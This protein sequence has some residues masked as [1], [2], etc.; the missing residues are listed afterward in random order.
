MSKEDIEKLDKQIEILKKDNH[1]ITTGEV[2]KVVTEIH[3]PNDENHIINISYINSEVKE[4]TKEIKNLKTLTTDVED[5]DDKVIE[6]TKKISVTKNLDAIE[7]LELE[8]ISTKVGD[9]KVN[10]KKSNKNLFIILSVIIGIL[11]LILVISLFIFGDNNDKEKD[12]TVIDEGETERVLS[13]DKMIEMV[14]LYG[15]TLEEEIT[16]YYNNSGVLPDFSTI[17]NLVNLDYEVVCHIHEIYKDKSI[18]LDECMVDYKDIDYTYGVKKEIKEEVVDNNNIKVYVHKKSNKATLEEPAD[19]D[20][21]YLYSSN[22]DGDIQNIN[23]IDGTSY[24]VYYDNNS[25]VYLEN[26]YNYVLGKKAFYKIDYKYALAIRDGSDYNKF[27]PYVILYNEN[28]YGKVYNL[29][30]GEAVTEEYHELNQ[31][32]VGKNRIIVGKDKKYGL[33]NFATGNI[34]I[35]LEY[36]SVSASGSSFLAIKNDKVFIF[37]EDGNQYLNDLAP[38]GFEKT[39]VNDKYVLY[40]KKLYNINGKELCEFEISDSVSLLH[41]QIIKDEVVYLIKEDNENK[42]LVYNIGK[43]DCS[44]LKQD[45][46]PKF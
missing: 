2:E 32:E 29:V 30:T 35:P 24:L 18:Y 28:D 21:Y 40:E 27:L 42:C 16:K 37:D 14:N 9:N 6:D 10:N 19:K 20:N 5:N 26:I 17:N 41:N 44:I 1:N 12:S 15:K 36:D 7:E 13:K 4:S 3:D 31:I 43:K 8:K 34:L 39:S 33:L 38:K 23:L 22:V 45:D 11:L 25:D 46:C